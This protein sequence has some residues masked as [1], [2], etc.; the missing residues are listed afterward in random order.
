VGT[1][2]EATADAT[3]PIITYSSV[4]P[5][6]GML[7]AGKTLVFD[8]TCSEAT[9]QSG[10]MSVNGNSTNV[11]LSG[12]TGT[13]PSYHYLVTY[14]VQATDNEKTIGSIPVSISIKD[15]AG[16]PSVA[17]TTSPTSVGVDLTAPVD[18]LASID[19]TS[20][21]SLNNTAA[22]FTFAAAEV[23]ATYSYTF[24]STGSATTKTGSGTISSATQQVTPVDLSTLADGTITLKVTLEDPAGNQGVEYT[25]TTKMMDATAPANVTG[26]SAVAGVGGLITLGWTEP[27]DP[28]YAF[29]NI[30]W[31]GGTA[32]IAKDTTS[33]TA[34]LA[35]GTYTFTFKSE[36]TKG[37]IQAV[38]TTKEATADAT[39]PII[40]YSS[41]TPSSGMLNAG[42]TL[43]FD[44]TC[45]EATLQSGVM[46]VNGNSTN[47]ALSG[48]TGTSPSY[49]YLVT[50]TVQATDNEK[51]IGSIPVS[52]SIK[53][54]AGNPS[55]AYTTSP[56]SVGVDLTAPVDYLASIDQTSFTSL[57]N[58]AASFT[59]AAAEVGATYSYTFS[60]TGSATTKTGSGTISSA[61][62]QVTPVDLS[63]LADGTITLKVTLEDPAG[64]QGVEYTATTK[65]MDATA[66]A[67]VT[68]IAASAVAGAKITLTWTDPSTVTYPDFDH[69]TVSWALSA[70]PTTII[71]TVT[72]AAAVQTY[73]SAAL[74]NGSAYTFTVKSVDDA[75]NTSTGASADAT[76][77]ND[78]PANVTLI[79]ASAVAGAKITLTWTD[80]ST[81]TYPDFDHVTVSWALSATPTTIIDTVTVAAAVQTY[82]SAALT[83]G[84]AYTFTVKSV[85]DAGNTSTGASADATADNDPPANVT[86]IA[87]SAVAGAKI[88]LTWTDPSTVTYPDF[89]HV[90]VSWALSATPTTIIDTVTVAAAVQTYTS[91]ALTNGSA[92][93]FTVKSVDDAGNTSAGA[94]AGATADNAAPANV[95]DFSA[96]AAAG[97]T[98]TLIWTDPVAATYP[99][100]DHVHISWTIDGSAGSTSDVAKGTQTKLLSSLTAGQVYVFTLSTLDT[101]GNS[102]AA[103]AM[104][105][106]ITVLTSLSSPTR[107]ATARTVSSATSTI[108]ATSAR[109]ARS[110]HSLIT[111]PAAD[112][113]RTIAAS[114]ASLPVTQKVVTGYLAGKSTQPAAVSST[115]TENTQAKAPVTAEKEGASESV[116]IPVRAIANARDERQDSK[117]AAATDIV[118]AI[119]A[120]ATDEER[121]EDAAM[122][123]SYSAPAGSQAQGGSAPAAPRSPDRA[124]SGYKPP[125]AMLAPS[126]ATGKPK[127]EEVIES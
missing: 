118:R 6:S 83:N 26:I 5:S 116:A 123:V 75:G 54:A 19:Q 7:N 33:T 68:L 100:F 59:F 90:T 46:S 80:P 74:T 57:N 87:A 117:V 52:I 64:N 103:T 3:V 71:D 2:K 41:V 24:S 76:A 105:G 32:R 70:T 27:L 107:T 21:T 25:A 22:S 121:A 9:L 51:T 112:D 18:Y 44:F 94:S 82:T 85:D 65:M 48:P 99:D 101:L 110:T 104:G 86:L 43:V 84:S 79:A 106:G 28:D 49:H 98:I 120:E 67:N 40:T 95:T 35:S 15:A 124:D 81:V 77:D 91:A 73:T 37:N 127:D 39:V 78:P 88:T 8:F 119:S 63:T 29:V 4:T 13:S 56:T 17:Y 12:P 66:P 55:V 109:S 96:T 62:Q 42:K 10:V 93:T 53:D 89:D 45:S 34:T 114:W 97:K 122:T 125:L 1:T 11:A 23:G 69:V 30:S 16:N 50:Y 113:T 115:R 20:F 14:T 108:T 31:T 58:T 126:R 60:S 36:D 111:V 72:V 61:T 38:G 92:Y 47:V 102:S